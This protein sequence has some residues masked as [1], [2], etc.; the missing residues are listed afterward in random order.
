MNPEVIIMIGQVLQF[1]A[2]I[3]LGGS[4]RH[5][6]DRRSVFAA[7]LLITG[8]AMMLIGLFKLSSV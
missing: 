3:A 2:I 5:S 1:V 6:S 7:G 8:S 4:N